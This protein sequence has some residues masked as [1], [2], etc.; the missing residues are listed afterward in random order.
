MYIVQ[1][2]HL[3][4]F[5]S[6]MDSKYL[7]KA[8]V[9]VATIVFSIYLYGYMY[10]GPNVINEH[11]GL[12]V[13]NEKC[14]S[15]DLGYNY[16]CGIIDGQNELSQLKKYRMLRGKAKIL[17]ESEKESNSKFQYEIYQLSGEGGVLFT[18]QETFRNLPTVGGACFRVEL[19]EYIGYNMH[20]KLCQV[21]D[22][23]TGNYTICCDPDSQ[24]WNISIFLMYTNYNAYHGV[25]SAQPLF[26]LLKMFKRNSLEVRSNPEWM[27]K[28]RYCDL[29]P[30]MDGRGHW[31][32]RNKTWLWTSDEGCILK[33]LT[34]TQISS[35][36]LKLHSLTFIG[37]SHMRYSWDYVVKFLPNVSNFN[38]SLPR[39]H[40]SSMKQNIYFE[41]CAH[42]SCL[43]DTMVKIYNN[44]KNEELS[45]NDIIAFQTGAWDIHDTRDVKNLILTQFPQFLNKFKQVKHM[46]GKPRLVLFTPVGYP[47]R[48]KQPYRRKRN[49]Y[50]IAA[51]KALLVQ[52]MREIRCDFLDVFQVVYP[53]VDDATPDNHHYM[54]PNYYT[55]NGLTFLHL[56]F[57]NI[58]QGIM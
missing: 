53:R 50:V 58:C 24:N 52:H 11:L 49:N 28:Y 43:Y 41:S 16:T 25:T 37:A 6:N 29:P 36:L 54:A 57:S 42:A 38:Q 48:N 23:F 32:L 7:F 45:A 12:N 8:A 10:I 9:C 19:R 27:N 33:S 2:N 15:C 34:E 39:K 47:Y 4:I 22:S 55:T 44:T 35:C 3:N 51:L 56:F 40:G 13:I 30:T 14:K 31:I 17:K 20:L 46:S 18:I 1:I 21:S 5:V 26:R